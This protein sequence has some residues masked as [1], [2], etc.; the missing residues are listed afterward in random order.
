MERQDWEGNQLDKDIIEEGNKL[1]SP[2]TCAFV[3]RDLNYFLN[4]HGGSRGAYP[5]GV[6][7]DKSTGRFRAQCRNPFTKRREVLGYFADPISAHQAWR[8]R[9]HE[10]ACQYADMQTD[11]RVAKALRLRFAPN[12]EGAE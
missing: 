1:Y 2:N 11:P 3:S 5:I 4:G 10:L 8:S 6:N 12:D 7:Q 9:K